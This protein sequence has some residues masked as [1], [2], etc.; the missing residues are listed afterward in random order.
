M[1][2]YS[3]DIM[4]LAQPVEK[5]QRKSKEPSK[6]KKEP[7]TLTPPATP[8]PDVAETPVEIK[9]K[10]VM[11][12]KQKEALKAGQEK[13]RLQ[14]IAMKEQAEAE[15][16]AHQ[17]KEKEQLEKKEAAKEKRRQAALKRKQESVEGQIDEAVTEVL[18][19]PKKVKKPK[20]S[21]D[22]PPVWF[23][24]YME[25]VKQEQASAK[26]PKTPK[27]QIQQEAHEEAKSKW[28]DGLVRDRLKNEVDG[29][30]NRMYGMIFG[31]RGMR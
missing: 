1:T 4:D 23:R 7:V 11:S 9:P 18:A 14:K 20:T 13:R 10:R 12:E 16:A 31:A 24:K 19:E 27:K 22:E 6:K 28:G 30:M 17:N 26:T 15:M 21:P 3:A 29:H 8:V 2:L 5:K 25:G